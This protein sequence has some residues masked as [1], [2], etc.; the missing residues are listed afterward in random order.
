MLKRSE[1]GRGNKD[2]E[3]HQATF[4]RPKDLNNVK[5]TWRRDEGKEVSTGEQM[6]Q[7]WLWNMNDDKIGKES[8]LPKVETGLIYPERK[9][10]NYP[11]SFVLKD[12]K[13]YPMTFKV[14]LRRTRSL[15]GVEA[16]SSFP[17][18]LVPDLP[19]PLQ[20]LL[21]RKARW[22]PIIIP[23]LKRKPKARDSSDS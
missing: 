20:L 19:K 15:R 23:F 22:M 13:E 12:H 1:L 21:S 16:S 11:G 18:I 3:E 14:C 17:N 2:P 10:R 4:R 9:P 8:L 7:R 5:D 6:L